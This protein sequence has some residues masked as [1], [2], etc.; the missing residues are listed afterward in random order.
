M[1]VKSDPHDC[2]SSPYKKYSLKKNFDTHKSQSSKRNDDQRQKGGSMLQYYNSVD[3]F[4]INNNMDKYIKLNL[5]N[6]I[7]QRKSNLKYLILIN[8]S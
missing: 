5:A 2:Y 1:K 6:Q 7:H 8:F 3:A 4:N